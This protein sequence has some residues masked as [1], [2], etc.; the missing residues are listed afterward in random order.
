[1]NISAN[2]RFLTQK[3]TGVQLYARQLH[4]WAISN[5]PGVRWYCPVSNRGGSSS[6]EIAKKV[7]VPVGPRGVS[8]HPWEQLILPRQVLGDV[9]FCPCNSAPLLTPRRTPLIVTIHCLAF[10]AV[11]QAFTLKYRLWY[12]FMTEVLS[13]RATGIISVSKSEAH[14]IMSLYP[15]SR[16]SI[17]VI[18][19]GVV[20][21]SEWNSLRDARASRSERAMVVKKSKELQLLFVGAPTAKKNFDQAMI[22][23]RKLQ[24][25]GYNC[26]L[27][28]AGAIPS[29]MLS[30]GADRDGKTGISFLG[31]VDDRGAM[32]DLYKKSDVLLFPSRFESSGLPPL[33]A[34]AAGCVAICS[35][36]PA[37]VERCGKG[38]LYCRD[39]S[40]VETANLV[41]RLFQGS[42]PINNILESAYSRVQDLFWED[43]SRRTFSW[44]HERAQERKRLISK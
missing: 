14:N 27:S 22:A 3:V 43:C 8:G 5:L 12:S 28:V 40:G 19:N 26:K 37:L 7:S 16:D 15:K 35:D 6:S 44:I 2:A 21:I 9:L 34:S 38:A 24:E 20:T 11:P 39:G 42:I 1:M 25:M 33:E 41:N 10:R 17:D 31:Q 36:L 18:E 4:S 32:L 30:S 29:G 23:V 13:R